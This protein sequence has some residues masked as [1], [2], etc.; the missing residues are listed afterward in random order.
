M[1]VWRRKKIIVLSIFAFLLFCSYSSLEAQSSS[2]GNLVGYVFERDGTTPF[3]GA[4]VVLKNI[5][6]ESIYYSTQSDSSG[7]FNIQG[8]DKGMYS[9]AV[10]TPQGGFNAE[11]I[12]GIFENKTT[13]ISIALDPYEPKVASAVEKVIREYKDEDKDEVLVG[14]VV[15]FNPA[16]GVAEV[17]II[18]GLLQRRDRIHIV[19]EL[20]D[21]NQD[22]EILRMD[23]ADVGS[24][25]AGQTAS[26]GVEYEC[27]VDDLVYIICKK[28]AVPFFFTPMG[29]AWILAGSSAII[30]ISKIE[31]EPCPACSVFIPSQVQ[32]NN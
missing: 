13:T 7:I 27:Q 12:I 19:G 11:Q 8:L 25:F 9:L 30:Y 20:T 32:K 6:T 26:L 3:E 4:N 24:V 16:T 2:K 14:R 18:K 5:A 28:R 21:F 10:S 31:E 23:E 17:F 29:I 22:V 1:K 15:S